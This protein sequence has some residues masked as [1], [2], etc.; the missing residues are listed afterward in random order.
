[1]YFKTLRKHYYLFNYIFL[2]CHSAPDAIAQDTCGSEGDS[3]DSES[4]SRILIRSA[5]VHQ[6][7]QN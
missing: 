3:S 7:M 1:M 4:D 2:T 5:Q 6:G